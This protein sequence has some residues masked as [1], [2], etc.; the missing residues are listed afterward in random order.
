M[1]RPWMPLQIIG[2]D[3]RSRIWLCM[4]SW[5]LSG[6]DSMSK[7]TLI[8]KEVCLRYQLPITI[9]YLLDQFPCSKLAPNSGCQHCQRIKFGG[10]KILHDRDACIFRSY[11]G[12]EDVLP[13][14]QPSC[15]TESNWFMLVDYVILHVHPA[16]QQLQQDTKYNKIITR[17]NKY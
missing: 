16:P 14:P 17:Y 8:F 6:N 13:D 5:V 2:L 9:I 7:A 4:L 15:L 10:S 1:L 11:L 12:G 3:E